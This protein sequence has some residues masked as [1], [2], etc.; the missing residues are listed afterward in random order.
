MHGGFGAKHP[1]NVVVPP[2]TGVV[3]PL[4]AGNP[5]FPSHFP[6]RDRFRGGRNGFAQAGY[7]GYGGDYA[8]YD[9]GGYAQTPGIVIMM[10]QF[11][12]PEPPA[13]PPPPIQPQVR[14]YNWPASGSSPVASAFSIVSR[15]GRERSAVA[16]WTQDNFL[17]YVAPNGSRERL[18]VESVDRDATIKRNAEKDLKLPLP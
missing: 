16:V 11:Q 14:E 2:L 9:N 8:A 1:G 10:P 18:P 5:G 7:P 6:G 12:M 17:N 3:P 4:G 13:P 15:D